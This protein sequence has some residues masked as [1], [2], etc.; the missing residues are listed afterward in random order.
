M[1]KILANKD[2]LY[3]ADENPNLISAANVL[4]QVLPFVGDYGISKNPESFAKENFR[5]Y[6]TDKKRGA[7]LRLSM[8]GLTPISLNGMKDWFRENL[9]D[10]TNQRL[11]GSYDH[12]K[13]HYNLTPVGKGRT[14]VFNENSKG[15]VSFRSFVP[16]SGQSMNNDYF[17]FKLG[18]IYKHHVGPI[19]T[20]YGG[21]SVNSTLTFVFNEAPSVVKSFRT[22]NYEGTQSKVY[23][24]FDDDQ[25]NNLNAKLGWSVS[26]VK[27][28]K[29]EGTVK[30]FIEKEG[31]WFNYIKGERSSIENFDTREF[32]FQGISTVSTTLDPPV[33]IVG[34]DQLHYGCEDAYYD[35]ANTVN[36]N[37]GSCL[38][39]IDPI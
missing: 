31:K 25:Y 6:F 11:I 15:W 17:T 18:K 14:A 3:N 33:L 4:G 23:P 22:M 39:I 13:S 32:S 28:D 29:Q 26:Y 10:D 1:L 38:D 24:R 2:A 36:I 37:T 27:T 34:A 5:S 16:E 30:E 21:A 9:E 7:V 20:F 12:H 8:D 19:N 35:P